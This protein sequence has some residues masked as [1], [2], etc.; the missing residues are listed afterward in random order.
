MTHLSNTI[1]ADKEVLVT[2]AEEVTAKRV[3]E[4]KTET[5]IGTKLSVE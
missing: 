4:W 5:A 3:T 2:E 1:N